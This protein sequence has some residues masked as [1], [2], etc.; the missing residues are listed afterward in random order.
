[1]TQ[2]IQSV[3]DRGIKD[4]IISYDIA[5]KY[6]IHFFNRVTQP[7]YPLLPSNL[8]SLADI[9]WLIG[10]F[11]IGGHKEDCQ[12]FFNFN[13]TKGV[14]R[15]SGELVETVW[16]YFD[17]LKYQTREMGPGSRQ[18]MLTDAM[19]F[20]NWQ[21]IVIIKSGDHSRAALLEATKQATHAQN[22]LK[23]IEEYIEPNTLAKLYSDESSL[24]SAQY[25]PDKSKTKFPTQRSVLDA[26]LQ[27]ESVTEEPKKPSSASKVSTNS[28]RR[29]RKTKGS[30]GKQQ[31]ASPQGIIDPGSS[32][33]KPIAQ[34]KKQLLKSISCI[35]AKSQATPS[36]SEVNT[37]EGAASTAVESDEDYEDLP[38]DD[39]PDS[40]QEMTAN[41]PASGDEPEGLPKVSPATFIHNA[42]KLETLQAKYVQLLGQQPSNGL[43]HLKQAY[44]LKLKSQKTKLEVGIKFH[45]QSLEK[46]APLVPASYLAP[47]APHK[48]PI[49]LPSNFEPDKW[50]EYG[51]LHL[52]AIEQK[53]RIGQAFDCLEKLKKALGVRSFLTRH[54][55]KS[56]GYR[57]A[58]RAQE[59]LK[60]AEVTVKQWAAAYRCVWDALMHLETPASKLRGLRPLLDGD[61]VL[62]SSWLE[63][64]KYRDRGVTLPW[65]WA[66]LPLKDKD[67]I[68]RSVSEWSAE[69]VRLEW[70]HARAALARWVEETHLLREELRRVHAFF[71]WVQ[72]DWI[73]RVDNLAG[74]ASPDGSDATQRGYKAYCLRQAYNYERLAKH[75][76]WNIEQSVNIG[77]FNFIS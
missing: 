57:V 61:L 55:R 62:L 6:S 12:K 48:D 52:A 70:L 30:T 42:L 38:S 4:I 49:T 31:S 65:I 68:E 7:P 71:Q 66:L 41:G 5:C 45:Y 73:A 16:A 13:Y 33:I 44:L 50:S 1:M 53:L 37:D 60:R 3:L 27:S 29:R 26:L 67:D 34:K 17:Y 23:G 35:R 56:N 10:K 74:A 28:K 40:P 36:Q 9:K 2:V 75:A 14:G 59:T 69:V 11:H 51:L 15:M 58:T 8:Q 22:R 77:Q 64:E 76:A 43:E 72:Q 19:N 24:S 20:W 39:D 47:K 25:L 21:K 54:A 63:E 46:L 18:E 32:P